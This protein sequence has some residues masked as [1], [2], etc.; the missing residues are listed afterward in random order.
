MCENR[1]AKS[2]AGAPGGPNP[3]LSFPPPPGH[4]GTL[5]TVFREKP[6]SHCAPGPV[7]C[8]CPTVC[9]VCGPS[10]EAM[11][12]Q[13]TQPQRETGGITLNRLCP[14]CANVEALPPTFSLCP[15]T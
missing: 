14:S 6:C 12:V 7:W 4:C 15:P 1:G 2:K 10:L 3:L 9:E 5:I 13:Q 11:R 8:G